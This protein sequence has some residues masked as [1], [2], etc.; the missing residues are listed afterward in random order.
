M[1][2]RVVVHALYD[3]DL[4]SS[5]PIRSYKNISTE[6]SDD[7]ITRTVTP[8]GWPRATPRRHVHRVQDEETTIEDTRRLYPNALA[9]S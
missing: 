6:K 1:I 4:A 7:R 3:I 2:V 8:K 5:R 9:V